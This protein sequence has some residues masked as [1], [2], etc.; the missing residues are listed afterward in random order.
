MQRLLLSAIDDNDEAEV[1]RILRYHLAEVCLTDEEN[2]VTTPFHDVCARDRPRL[3][4]LFLRYGGNEILNHCDFWGITPLILAVTNR[5]RE[6]VRLLV[7]DK[8][9]D[10]NRRRTHGQTPLVYAL[11]CRYADIVKL[12]IASGRLVD[13]TRERLQHGLRHLCDSPSDPTLMDVMEKYLENPERNVFQVQRELKMP[14]AESAALY[15][16]IVFFCDDYLR[17]KATIPVFPMISQRTVTLVWRF[18]AL[19][20]RLPLELQMT[21]C[22]RVFSNRGGLIPSSMVESAF[23]A[24]G[25]YCGYNDNFERMIMEASRFCF[26]RRRQ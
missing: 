23:L 10:V 24:L 18:F 4:S 11:S 25:T 1:E 26:S 2:T 15:A 19:S 14:A 20:S 16:I 3:V 21:I 6:T 22:C 12:L 8:R 17:L 9:V 7:A 5:R 13:V